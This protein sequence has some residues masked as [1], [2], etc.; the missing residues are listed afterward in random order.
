MGNLSRVRA[1]LLFFA[2]AAAGVLSPWAVSSAAAAPTASFTWTPTTPNT[3]ETVHLD[4]S[5]STGSGTLHYHWETTTTTNGDFNDLPDSPTPTI[6]YATRGPHVIQLKVSDSSST[7]PVVEHTITVNGFPAAAFHFAPTDPQTGDDVTFTSDSTDPEGNGTIQSYA[8]DV[9][10]DGFDD[11][12]QSTLTTSF[13][14]PGDK[15]VALRVTDDNGAQNTTS[16][17]VT[18]ADRG[19]TSSFDYSPALPQPDETVTFTSTAQDPDDAITDYAWDIDGDGFD[20]GTDP[21]LSVAF[22][23]SGTRTVRLQVTD[24]SGE[25]DVASQTVNVDRPPTVSFVQDPSPAFTDETVTLSATATDPDGT[26]TG[27]LWDLNG[28]GIFGDATGPK[29]TTAFPLPGT[30]TVHVRATDDD[31]ATTER[32]GNVTVVDRVPISLPLPPIAPPVVTPPATTAR[33]RLSPFPKVRIA[34]RLTRRGARL[35]LV[36]IDAPAGATIQV[37]CS[38]RSCPFKK[39]VIPPKSTARLGG[40]VRM[41]ALERSLRAGVMIVVRVFEPGRIGKYTGLRIRR[42]KAPRRA[43]RCVTSATAAPIVCPA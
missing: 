19:P 40:V 30:Y 1:V 38:G 20:D 26:V 23:T 11:G 8:W 41:A 32:A 29:A 2:V 16:H 22:P 6:A 18:V 39:R 33:T 28:D 35:R 36:T 17:T 5:A 24:A 21:T 43:D 3:D 42:G 7:S 34:G 13:A 10:G 14:S 25:T 15:S 4:A 12:T 31:G 27:V 37:T 9:D